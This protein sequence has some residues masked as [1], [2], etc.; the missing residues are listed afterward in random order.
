MVLRPKRARVAVGARL[1]LPAQEVVDHDRAALLGLDAPH[2]DEVVAEEVE[3]RGHLVDRHRRRPLDA[4]A[5]HLPGQPLVAGHPL[6]EVLLLRGVEDDR[7]G[8]AEEVAEEAEVEDAVVLGGGDEEALAR[9]HLHPE[10]GRPVAVGEEDDR[11]V[12]LLVARGGGRRGAGTTGPCSSSHRRSSS[13]VC[14]KKQTLFATGKKTSSR[15]SPGDRE[16]AHGDAVHPRDA[17]G[18]DVLPGQV[19]GGGGGEDLDLVAR[20]HVLGHPAAVQLGPAHHLGPVALD[21]EGDPQPRPA[22]P[23]LRSFCRASTRLRSAAVSTC[24]RTSSRTRLWPR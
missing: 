24:R 1:P 15:R 12:V 13:S 2:V 21:D 7:R 6:D 17:R 16:A 9:R 4:G 3:A 11:V 18:Q 19:V 8:Q 10:V 14:S 5:H 23:P 22:S 20:G